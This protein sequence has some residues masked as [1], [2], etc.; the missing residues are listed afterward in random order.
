M[1]KG[2][3][4][5]L[6]EEYMRSGTCCQGVFGLAQ[7]KRMKNR[8]NSSVKRLFTA[9]SL[10]IAL[11]VGFCS[12]ATASGDQKA[13]NE[14]LQFMTQR[15]GDYSQ[16]VEKR[17]VRFLMS[18]NKT[19]FYLD[20]AEKR[21]LSYDTAMRFEKFV[22]DQL[23]KKHLKVHVVIIP[24]E[25]S[26]LFSRVTEGYGDIAVGN[27]TI[28]D[29]R[30]KLVDFSDPF[31]ENVEEVV[32]TQKSVPDLK[33]AMELAGKEI[34]VTKSSSYYESLL[35][36][37]DALIATGKKPV[38]IT[39]ADEHLEDADLLEMLDAGAVPMLVVDKHKADFWVTILDNIKIHPE[40]SVHSGG[41]IAWAFRKDSPELQEVVNA[42]VKVNKKGTLLGNM[43][44]KKYLKSNKYIKNPV[45]AE[46]Q[47]RLQEILQFFKVYG[48]K[49]DFPYLILTALAYQ[50]SRLD[51]NAKSHVGAIG[52]MQMLPSTAKDK[53]V[54]IPDIQ[55][56][57]ANIH[58]GSKYLRFLA[59]RYFSDPGIEKL[60]KG[61][62]AFAAYN[63]GPAKV[64]RLRKEAK[65]MG[66][67][68][69]IWFHNVEVVAA[70]RIGRETVQYV[71]NIFKYYVIYSLMES[72]GKI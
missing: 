70:K 9:I 44:F 56:A 1:A 69:N 25:R 10:M 17:V 29:E 34:Y 7:E 6:R 33:S 71:S 42:F 45:T 46:G 13:E 11:G 28:T 32:V 41:Q 23:K 20:G 27:L 43:A 31:L 65:E 53:N 30:K 15:K 64:T 68:P 61:L 36:L 47:K 50:E 39:L 54:N 62:F 59:D 58:A 57:E 3:S 26:N 22:N 18:F 2:C 12:P 72:Q 52:V 55:K 8:K 4:G 38:K 49:Y 51:Q 21:G 66:L 24:T 60:D 14:L 16:M 63:A 40:A 5:L 67:D 48:E 19:F 35:K 37:N